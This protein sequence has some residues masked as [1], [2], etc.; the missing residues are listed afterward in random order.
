MVKGRKTCVCFIPSQKIRILLVLDLIAM[1]MIST[2]N[3]CVK[4]GE[5]VEGGDNRRE[6]R[7]LLTK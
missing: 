2:L 5:K 7:G 6:D 1:K 3:A 4:C